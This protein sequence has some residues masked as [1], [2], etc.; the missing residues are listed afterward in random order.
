M[1]WDNRLGS[2][3]NLTGRHYNTFGHTSVHIGGNFGKQICKCPKF[4]M[5]HKKFINEVEIL[6]FS[7]E[8][9]QNVTEGRIIFI[10]DIF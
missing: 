6:L 5:R 3:I 4:A 8:N 9:N 10:F 7:N 2:L 1:I